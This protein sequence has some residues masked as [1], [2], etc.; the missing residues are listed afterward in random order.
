LKIFSKVRR[1]FALKIFIIC[2]LFY[3]FLKFK[4]NDPTVN[5]ANPRQAQTFCPLT[6]PQR[7]NSLA[8]LSERHK[9]LIGITEMNNMLQEQEALQTKE[10]ED[11]MQIKN[12]HERAIAHANYC[13][14]YFD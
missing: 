14:K 12:K 11:L 1:I 13:I 10:Y 5:K 4:V 7:K 8:N 6:N 3:L 9:P 2:R